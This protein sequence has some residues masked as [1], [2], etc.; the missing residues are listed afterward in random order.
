METRCISC[1]EKRKY[2]KD[3]MCTFCRNGYGGITKEIKMTE[4]NYQPNTQPY[5]GEIEGRSK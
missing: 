1:G 5:N 4:K 2:L 3:G